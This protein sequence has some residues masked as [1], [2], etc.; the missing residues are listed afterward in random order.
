MGQPGHHGLIII[1]I[2]II[3]LNR[4]ASSLDR[5]RYRALPVFD[6]EHQLVSVYFGCG[7]GG[8]KGPPVWNIQIALMDD[9]SII[10]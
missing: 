6:G 8:K 1:I 3:S 2:T 7:H 9:G 5:M 4:S 10:P